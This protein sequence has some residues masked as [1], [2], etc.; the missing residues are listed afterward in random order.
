MI[1]Y[2]YN[3]LSKDGAKVKGII[4][5]VDEY[6][7][8]EK[9][10][11]TNSIVLDIQE[12]KTGGIFSILNKEVGKKVDSKSLSVMCSQFAIILNA[13]T[14]ISQTIKLIASQTEDKKLKKMLEAA[15]FDV[16]HG[17]TVEQAF[18]KKL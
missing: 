4:E 15:Y 5:A 11:E 13:G 17:S 6:Q 14:P 3:A 8:I 9:I 7:A 18:R 1:S 2:K 16:Q 12:V 10:K